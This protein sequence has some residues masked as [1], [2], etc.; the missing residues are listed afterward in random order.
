MDLS[1]NVCSKRT[2]YTH[3][4]ESQYHKR[5]KFR[6]APQ[7]GSLKKENNMA[8]VYNKIRVR[9]ENARIIYT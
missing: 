7:T 1:W 9:G 8:R 3:L 6:F 5:F 2:R 4:K